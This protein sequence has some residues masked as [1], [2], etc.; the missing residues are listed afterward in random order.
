[1]VPIWDDKAV[2]ELEVRIS[3][4]EIV[5]SK[6]PES[7]KSRILVYATIKQLM[8]NSVGRECFA[9][10][11]KQIVEGLDISTHNKKGTTPL[12]AVA[13]SGHLEILRL[14]LDEKA[15]INAADNDGVTPLVA[16]DNKECKKELKSMGADGWTAL[17]IAVDC[18]PK[19]VEQ[20]FNYREVYL[21]LRNRLPFPVWFRDMVQRFDNLRTAGWTWGAYEISSLNLSDDRL[22]VDKTNSSPD[23]SCAVGSLEFHQG[24]HTWIIQVENVRAMWLGIARGVEEKGGLGSAPGNEG[25]FMLVFSSSDGSA[26]VLGDIEPVIERISKASFSSCQLIEFELNTFE[27]CL[28]VSIDGELAV[29][30]RNIDD[31]GVRP[32]VC[33]DYDESATII[34]RSFVA[35]RSSTVSDEMS[36]SSA[37][38]ASIKDAEYGWDNALWSE[39]SDIYLAALNITG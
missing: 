3:Q 37:S 34:S 7:V 25:D 12:H 26:T 8:A 36:V 10:A 18:G 35:S 1:M 2:R 38:D 23:Y 13:K 32:Y 16:A 4:L 17:M 31:K 11:Y 29:I 15:D 30:A 20:Y 24:I 27:H 39:Q 19:A 9:I 5:R 28:K 14:L 21:C 22:S 33:M 6:D